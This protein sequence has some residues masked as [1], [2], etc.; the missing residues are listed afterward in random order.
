MTY[1]TFDVLD[2]TGVRGQIPLLQDDTGGIFF[3][4]TLDAVSFAAL[5]NIVPQGVFTDAVLHEDLNGRLSLWLLGYEIF[6]L[7]ESK[8]WGNKKTGCSLCG[9]PG[10][11]VRTALWCPQHNKLI[12]GF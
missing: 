2:I 8:D 5:E 6:K 12:G 7:A 1:K 3:T 4:Y 10:V 9:D 11:F